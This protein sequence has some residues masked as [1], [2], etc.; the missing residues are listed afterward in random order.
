MS[1]GERIL[2]GSDG[3]NEDSSIDILDVIPERLKMQTEGAERGKKVD[4]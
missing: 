1:L 2:A 4:L 3:E